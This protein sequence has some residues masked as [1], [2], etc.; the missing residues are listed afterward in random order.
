[1][2]SSRA[3]RR[4]ISLAV[5]IRPH[6]GMA[7]RPAR[8]QARH[9][10]GRPAPRLHLP[11]GRPPHRHR[12]PSCGGGKELRPGPAGD[13]SPT[14]TRRRLD[15]DLR[16]RPGRQPDRR[17]PGP[18]NARR[19]EAPR[20]P[21]LHRHPHH[22]ARATSAT[23]TTTRAASPCARRP[24]CRRSPTPGATVGRRGPP[25][26]RASPPTA[27]RW[28]YTYDP[29]G[30]RTAKHRLAADGATRRRSRC[31]SPGTAPPSASRPPRPRHSR[32]RVTLTWDHD[33]LR[34]LDP[35]RSASPP[36]DAPRTRSTPA[37][38]PSSPT[39]SAPPPNSSTSTGDIAWRTRT[40]LWGT[41]T[42][43]GNAHRL[44]TAAFPR[45]VLRPRNRPPLQLLPP[46]RPRD[47]PLHHPRPP[48]PH[49]RPQPH[50]LRPQS[51]YRGPTPS[52][53]RHTATVRSPNPMAP[54]GRLCA[55]MLTMN[56]PP[57]E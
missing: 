40:T 2:S 5:A 12:R 4:T 56:T 34:P 1:M 46:L 37:S 45:P 3:H 28:R 8:A 19:T 31:T 41:T 57:S 9:R 26:R 21:H 15:R 23:N 32:T 38:S 7:G 27:P 13:G 55:G 11:G 54:V 36:A 48:R 6:L 42:W 17:P 20:L 43:N 16:L 29:L 22:S 49:T 52:A 33:G 53:S 30:R 10:R 18:T 39:S 44:H 51:P 14:V 47:R 24:A 50:H 35:D 25:R